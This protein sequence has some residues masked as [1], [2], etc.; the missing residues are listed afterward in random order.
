MG[1][2]AATI[3]CI[4]QFACIQVG[5]TLPQAERYVRLVRYVDKAA[6]KVYERLRDLTTEHPDGL[7]SV[8]G[9]IGQTE[10]DDPGEPVPSELGRAVEPLVYAKRA[11]ERADVLRRKMFER[12]IL[13]KHLSHDDLIDSVCEEVGAFK[14]QLERYLLVKR[15]CD[16]LDDRK[17]NEVLKLARSQ[18]LVLCAHIRKL[19][20]EGQW[21]DPGE[22]SFTT[23]T[24]PIVMESLVDEDDF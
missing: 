5:C 1:S 20:A 22:A 16:G 11:Y 10:V 6:P 18:T 23:Y 13:D 15:Y 12:W 2:K 7:M 24:P 14:P 3:M 19:I 4:R 9:L 8:L 17:R 21:R